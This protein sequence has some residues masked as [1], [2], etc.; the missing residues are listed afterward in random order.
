MKT[1]IAIL[2]LGTTLLAVL[3]EMVRNTMDTN[4]GADA[5][6]RKKHPFPAPQDIA[7][8]QDHQIVVHSAVPKRVTTFVAAQ[9]LLPPGV[10]LVRNLRRNINYGDQVRGHGHLSDQHPTCRTPARQTDMGG[11]GR[12]PQRGVF[13]LYS[14]TKALQTRRSQA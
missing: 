2:I 6:L 7:A 9:P 10:G 14:D 5:L 12:R 1:I 8:S 11:G 4:N 13:H 3:A